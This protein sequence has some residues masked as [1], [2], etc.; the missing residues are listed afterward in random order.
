MDR[1]RSPVADAVGDAAAD[2]LQGTDLVRSQ[3]VENV[4]SDRPHVTGG[5]TDPPSAQML[6]TSR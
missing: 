4:A 1:F 6:A 2:I 3:R 5:G